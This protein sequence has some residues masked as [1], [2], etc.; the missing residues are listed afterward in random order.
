MK[1]SSFIFILAL[2]FS[3]IG[4]SQ[5]INEIKGNYTA[6]VDVA[7]MITGFNPAAFDKAK[8]QIADTFAFAELK[9]VITPS[10]DNSNAQIKDTFAVEEIN[11]AIGFSENAT[12]N[13]PKVNVTIADNYIILDKV[14]G[15]NKKLSFN[16]KGIKVEKNQFI[17]TTLENET[18]IIT[19]EKGYIA[20]DYQ[21]N[22]LKIKI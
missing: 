17:I 3:L 16:S 19:K 15:V 5:S 7:G 12:T 4:K 9:K 20:I 21:K 6:E 2:F 8:N 13:N 22:K 14:G 18:V 10:E 1:T 11:K